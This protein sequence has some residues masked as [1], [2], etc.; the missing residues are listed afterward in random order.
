VNA[1]F[2]P[3]AI[4]QDMNKRIFIKKYGVKIDVPSYYVLD[5]KIYPGDGNY[6]L[7]VIKYSM[8]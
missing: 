7:K 1:D 6:S 4:N 8:P 5:A 2:D 3:G